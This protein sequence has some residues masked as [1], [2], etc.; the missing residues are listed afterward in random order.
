MKTLAVLLIA[1]TALAGN[2][3]AEI[4]IGGSLSGSFGGGAGFTIPYT[5]ANA[6]DVLVVG[7]YIDNN[8]SAISSFNFNGLNPNGSFLASSGNGSR[9]S[10]YY[11]MNPTVGTFNFSGT[12][13]AQGNS[14]YMIWEL[15]GVDLTAP[16]AL[17]SP[18]PS[19][20]GGTTITTTLDN[21]LILDIS[22][23]NNGGSPS[24]PDADSVL[25]KIGEVD[26]NALFG[27]GYMSTG[28][29]TQATPGTYNLGWTT[30][31]SPAGS[32]AGEVAFAFAPIAVPEP[33]TLSLVGLSLV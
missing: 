27:G 29:S 30:S 8:D 17:S 16:V 3:S 33:C 32:Q 7:L 10:A 18:T 24:I 11:F 23:V 20:N 4:T 19:L 9:L 1:V 12:S 6:N 25:T 15:S 31:A 2:A 22:T 14:G 26:M 13:I 5:V 28:T 21:S